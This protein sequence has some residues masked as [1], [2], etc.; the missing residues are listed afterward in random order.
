MSHTT[1]HT[2]DPQ[3]PDTQPEQPYKLSPTTVGWVVFWCVLSLAIAI[4][5]VDVVTQNYGMALY[6][7]I[8]LTIGFL[9]GFLVRNLKG[10]IS[11]ALVVLLVTTLLCLLLMVFKLEG[12]I[13]II[14]I[15]IPLYAI[16]AVG[17]VLGRLLWNVVPKYKS[18]FMLLLLVNPAC[19]AYDTQIEMVSNTI[20]TQTTIQATP[21]QVW[22]VLISGVDFGK[23]E[24]FFFKNGVNYPLSMRLTHRN[25]SLL[26]HCNLRNSITELYVDQLIPYTSMRFRS[27]HDVEPVKELTF[28]DTIS[29]P[30]TTGEYFKHHYGQF[31]LH[32][33]PNGTTQLIAESQFSYKLAPAIYWNWWSQYLVKTMHHHVLHTIKDRSEN[34]P[35]TSLTHL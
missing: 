18:Y 17:L 7:G 1:N 11:K 23:N 21:A 22:Q 12:A 27:V 24:N 5:G 13:C 2:P 33:L 10:L 26:L 14:M 31:R 28:Y 3:V 20:T 4:I 16:I 8:P 6:L 35:A 25:D 15:M 29:T 32:Q 9:V 19:I 34:R 30:H